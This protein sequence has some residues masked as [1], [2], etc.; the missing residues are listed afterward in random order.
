M[1]KF[2][3]LTIL[4]FLRILYEPP[5]QTPPAFNKIKFKQETELKAGAQNKMARFARLP[6]LRDADLLR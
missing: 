6:D 4:L 2:T 1:I 3:A 5:K